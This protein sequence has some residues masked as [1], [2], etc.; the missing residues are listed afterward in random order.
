MKN[1]SKTLTAAGLAALLST[2]ALAAIN[3]IR[4]LKDGSQVTLNGTV[5]S[6]Q[7]ER[8]FTLRDET[9]KIGIDIKSGESVVL[10]AGDNVTVNGMVDKSLLGTDINARNVTVDKTIARAIGDT[11][12]GNTS[13]SLEG[14]TMYNIKSLPK[15]GLVKV[16]GTVTKVD[17]EK[18]FT[19][20]DSTGSIKVDVKSAETAELA[21]GAQVTVIGYVDSG[22][23]TK[24][25]DARKVLVVADASASR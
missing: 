7:N 3:N 6:V 4:D 23:F 25:I 24:D 10:K 20:K 11:I 12:E 5:D 17:N 13:M 18:K 1:F 15:E 14:A 9:G 16:S 22:I 21:K 2:S 8:E 19:V